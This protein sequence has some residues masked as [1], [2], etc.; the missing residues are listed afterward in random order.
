ME[1]KILKKLDDMSSQF[2]L[3]LQGI[4]QRMDGFDQKFESIDQRFESI[5]QRFEK[6][7]RRFD[8]IDKKIE[9]TEENIITT[10]RDEF[11][12]KLEET[13]KT[14]SK[15]VGKQINALCVSVEKWGNGRHSEI[16]QEIREHKA[17]TLKGVKAL[18]KVLTA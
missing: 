11:D 5:D 1:E 16:K 13:V 4:N 3:Q 6:I 7:D 8:E 10:L 17:R 9:E 18:E 14:I 12:Q 15:D 2:Q